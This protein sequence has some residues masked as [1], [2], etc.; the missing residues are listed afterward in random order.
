MNTILFDGQNMEAALY[1]TIGV[2]P[3]TTRNRVIDFNIVH[4][5]LNGVSV[6]ATFWSGTPKYEY[7]APRS[8]GDSA[9]G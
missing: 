3:L 7:S 8:G 1:L 5:F 2:E 6:I 4:G 9:R